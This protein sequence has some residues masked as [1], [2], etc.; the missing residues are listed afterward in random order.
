RIGNH[1]IAKSNSA[2]ALAEGAVL[3]C[4]LVVQDQGAAAP[5]GHAM[6]SVGRVV[7]EIDT[8]LAACLANAVSSA[9]RISV[10]DHTIKNNHLVAPEIA[11]AVG[12][13]VSKHDTTVKD[14]NCFRTND[15]AVAGTI[16][17][18]E[19]VAAKG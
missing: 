12:A 13:I 17:V 6:I 18:L 9:S 5:P 14:D 2:A 19:S 10:I 8:V 15:A 11:T 16:A 1:A 3:Q 4:E 7:G